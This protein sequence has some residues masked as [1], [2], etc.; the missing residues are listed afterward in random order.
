MLFRSDL[1]ASVTTPDPG[2]GQ[3]A[4]II[5]TSYDTSLRAITSVHPDGTI[6]STEYFTTGAVKKTWGSRVYPV[7][8]TYDA[9]GRLKTMK[10]WQ[11]FSGNSGTATTT[12]NYD[13]YRGFL[14]SKR[15]ADNTGPDY[16]N[17]MG[18]RLKSRTWARSYAGG[19]RITTLYKYGF[20]DSLSGNQHGDLTEISYNDGITPTVT[21]V[22]DRRGRQISVTRAGSTTTRTYADFGALLSEAITGGTLSGWGVSYAY[23]THNRRQALTTTNGG[24]TLTG[25]SYA[26]DNASRL[27]TVTEGTLQQ[28]TAANPRKLSNLKGEYMKTT[29][30]RALVEISGDNG[31]ADHG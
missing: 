7:E 13:A 31:P 30:Y 4:Q 3:I 29:I 6:T 26:Y 12:W 1:V 8:Y 11:N 22:Y 20:D 21:Q 15:Y 2:N 10:T 25:V 18:G 19:G 17:T 24:S 14:Q 16:T 28:A 5:S 9:Q 23:D 27:D